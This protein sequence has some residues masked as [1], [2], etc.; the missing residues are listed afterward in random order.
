MSSKK[1]KTVESERFSQKECDSSFESQNTLEPGST[2]TVTPIV[3]SPPL[4]VKTRKYTDPEEMKKAMTKYFNDCDAEEKS[5]SIEGLA[6]ACGF[7]STESLRVYEKGVTY[8]AFHDLVKSAKLV[9]QQQR[10]EHL[11]DGK[12]NP[13]AGM[14]LLKNSHKVD[15]KPDSELSGEDGSIDKL[16]NGFNFKRNPKQ[17]VTDGQ[18]D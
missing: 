2:S 5:Y 6:L 9:I 12:T 15:Y 1:V 3:K 11:Q 18:N 14:F 10:V 13:L 7:S 16:L 17:E 4:L 8:E